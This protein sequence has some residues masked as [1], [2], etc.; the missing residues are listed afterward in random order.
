VIN[1]LIDDLQT[2]LL[3]VHR[4]YVL[5]DVCASWRRQKNVS[6]SLQLHMRMLL[7]QV[8]EYSHALEGRLEEEKLTLFAGV[9]VH[10][11]LE[12]TRAS[13]SFVANFALM[14]FLCARGNL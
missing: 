8:N 7:F 4:P 5:C 9:T 3:S 11:C 1:H 6:H 12:R 14:L 2:Q 10:M 13:K